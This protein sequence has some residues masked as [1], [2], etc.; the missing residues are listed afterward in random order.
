ML[1]CDRIDMSE[2]ID[3][4]KTD[5]SHRCIICNIIAFLKQILDFSQNHV[6][7]VII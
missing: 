2:G 3:V 5:E 7:V 6:M 4:N 1:E